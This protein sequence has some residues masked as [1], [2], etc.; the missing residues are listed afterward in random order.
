[1]SKRTYDAVTTGS[2]LLIAA[3]AFL[4]DKFSHFG[5]LFGGIAV[6]CALVSTWIY[7]RH[8]MKKAREGDG[9]SDHSVD[10]D[11]ETM[12]VA[13]ATDRAAT[14]FEVSEEIACSKRDELLASDEAEQLEG[15]KDA[16]ENLHPTAGRFLGTINALQVTSFY[17]SNLIVKQPQ[18]TFADEVVEIVKGLT[19][20]GDNPMYEFEFKPDGS[21]RVVPCALRVRRADERKRLTENFESMELQSRVFH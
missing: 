5:W 18:R 20:P 14:S 2:L 3:S 16:D 19:E 15:R 4:S 21:F 8:G 1:M 12:T 7:F 17:L 10:C 9:R 13:S 11:T 6:S